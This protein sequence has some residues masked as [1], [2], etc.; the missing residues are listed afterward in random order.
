V[1]ASGFN[2]SGL[3]IGACRDCRA[4]V[5]HA[6]AERNALGYSGTNSGGHLVIERSVFRDNAFGVAPNSLNN[7]DQPPPQDG[8][9]DAGANRTPLPEFASTAIA[10][11]T[12]I[13]DNLIAGNNNLTTPVNSA[14]TAPWGVGVELPGTYADLVRDN[15]IRG[16]ANFGVLAFENPNPFPPTAR[17][18]EF[19]TS[20]NA[21]IHNRFSGNGTRP[22]GA[23][24]GLE[25]GAF[26]TRRS[27]NDCFARNTFTTS[28]PA[29]VEGTWGCQN[30]TT[31]NGGTQ[32]VG[33]IVALQAEAAARRPRGQP[34]PPAQPSMPRPCRG[35]PR[36]VL[37]R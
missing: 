8:A 37:C 36:N 35:V 29:D 18:I 32:L 25:G 22:G 1:Y 34:A 16:N 23:D 21:V 30:A 14:S 11:C 5:R 24:I 26:G 31:P 7:D 3:Y 20:G 6:L 27:V 19:Q 10:R 15:T 28:I 13:R 2:D 12:I 33:T 9:C 17:T 4:L